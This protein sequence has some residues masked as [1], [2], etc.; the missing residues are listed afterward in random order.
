MLFYYHHF[1]QSLAALQFGQR[2]WFRIIRK[3]KTKPLSLRHHHLRQLHWFQHNL[4]YFLKIDISEIQLKYFKIETN[5]PI[6]LKSV[7]TSSSLGV[8]A[9]GVN[10]AR[11]LSISSCNLVNVEDRW[12]SCWG[13][14]CSKLSFTLVLAMMC[15]CCFSTVLT[16]FS[17]FVFSSWSA[18]S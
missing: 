13:C 7:S 3:V 9:I 18:L 11:S 6:R 10:G 15:F 8:A 14:C 4:W 16:S 5:L 17:C 12:H 2:L 1:F